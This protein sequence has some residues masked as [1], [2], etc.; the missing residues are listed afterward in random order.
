MHD[1]TYMTRARIK[2]PSWRSLAVTPKGRSIKVETKPYFCYDF[3]YTFTCKVLSRYLK[4]IILSS[5]HLGFD[6]RN[7]GKG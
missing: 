2:L 6:Y 7:V 5:K 3:F 4:R 1:I